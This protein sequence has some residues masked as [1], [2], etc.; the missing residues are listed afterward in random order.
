MENTTLEIIAPTVEEATEQGLAQLGLTAEQVTVEVLDAGSKGFLGIGG[1]Q[2]RVRLSVKQPAAPNAPALAT[3]PKPAA[4]SQPATDEDPTLS[5]ARETLSTLLIG[6]KLEATVEAHY[7]EE[8][9]DKTRR[10]IQLDIQGEELT[11]L[12]GRR[13]ETLNA[14]QYIAGLIISKQ[15]GYWVQVV[16]DVGGYRARREK[17]LR[18]LARRMAD[19]AIRTGKKQLLEPMSAGDRRIVHLELREVPEVT[20][21]EQIEHLAHLGRLVVVTEGAAGCRL[22]WNGDSRRFRAPQ[23][24]EVDATGAGDI[25]ATA[26]FVR[27]LNTRDPWEA[28]RFAVNLAAHSVTRP[29]LS[30]IPTQS[31][32]NTCLT[33]ILQ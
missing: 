33:E 27:L 30:G 21:E 23:M 22:F 3:A 24:Q 12:I 11:V 10:T 19:Q 5:F 29:S 1:R 18:Q 32:I 8:G 6:M 9:E 26:F 15:V 28:A 2:V 31:E 16:I 13:S 7:V 25:F 4:P 17:Q 20:N 14:L